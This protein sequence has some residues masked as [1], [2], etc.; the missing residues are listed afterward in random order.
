MCIFLLQQPSI[1]L[2]GLYSKLEKHHLQMQDGADLQESPG[3]CPKFQRVKSQ[4][5]KS[6]AAL[7]VFIN[8]FPPCI[9]VP[10]E[11]GQG[12]SGKTLN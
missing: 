10:G 2:A 3:M 5:K 7:L 9:S 8:P 6:K 4:Q 1:H 11:N 12:V